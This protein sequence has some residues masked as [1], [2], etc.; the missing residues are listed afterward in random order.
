MKDCNV[1]KDCE[2]SCQFQYSTRL[3][4]AMRVRRT[5]CLCWNLSRQDLRPLHWRHPQSKDNMGA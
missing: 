3:I 1:N 2:V 4:R 5:T